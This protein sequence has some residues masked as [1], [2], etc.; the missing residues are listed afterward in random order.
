[1]KPSE[2]ER[3]LL[4]GR[5]QFGLRDGDLRPDLLVELA[6]ELEDADLRGPAVQELLERPTAVLTWDDVT[7]LG[8]LLLREMGY[9][10]GPWAV[11]EE[12]LRVVERDVRAARLE[13]EV[14][15]VLPDWDPSGCARA[16]FGEDAYGP[17]LCPT[18]DRDVALPYVADALQEVV[19]EAAWLVWPVCPVHQMGLHPHEAVWRC[20][21]PRSGGHVVCAIGEFPG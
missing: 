20:G 1:M 3:M 4:A 6:C 9:E 13:G 15:L 16:G 5:V 2:Q 10:R 21:D 11:M 8:R 19:M 14:R 7:R 17:Q 12:A 18:D